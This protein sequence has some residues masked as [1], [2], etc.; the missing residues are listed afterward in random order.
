[1]KMIVRV[2][3]A[4]CKNGVELKFEET[5]YYYKV[6]VGNKTWYWDKD[7]GEY[8]G[9][10]ETKPSSS[11]F[12]ILSRLNRVFRLRKTRKIDSWDDVRQQLIDAIE[13]EERINKPVKMSTALE[14]PVY[15]GNKSIFSTATE[16][17]ANIN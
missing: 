9:W 2:K 12:P 14:S 15:S 3:G 4:R 1:M 13:K 17:G 5:P 10:G 16:E 6:T 11:S 8:D 7:T